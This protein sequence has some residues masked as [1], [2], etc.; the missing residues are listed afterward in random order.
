[1]I[2]VNIAQ[3]DVTLKLDLAGVIR[4]A[5]LGDKISDANLQSWVGRNWAETV[6]DIGADKV[7]RMVWDARNSGVSGFRQVTQ[8]FPSGLELP[9][10]YTTIRLGDNSGLIAVGKSLQAVAELQSRL[11][12]A[13][14]AMERDYWKFREVETRYRLLFDAS[15]EAVLLM[16]AAD[17]VIIE[18]NPAALRS[19]GAGVANGQFLQEID[20]AEREA[21]RAVLLRA[22]EQ[23]RA[24]GMV[25]HLG[26][27]LDPWLLRVSTM[28]A[29]PGPLFLLQLTPAGIAAPIEPSTDPFA[30]PALIAELPEGLVVIDLDG[31]IRRANN[32]FVELIQANGEGG[33]V[34]EKLERWLRA[35]GA[36]LTVILANVRRYNV[37]RQFATTIYDELDAP[38]NVVIAA[39]MQG[40]GDNRS[41][42][43]LFH[44]GEQP[45]GHSQ[46]AALDGITLEVGS[47]P[48]RILLQETVGRLER[49]YIE[50]ALE[51]ASGN[52]TASAELLGLSRQSLYAKLNR[53]GLDGGAR[54][55][56]QRDE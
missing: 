21:F 45:S 32:A 41:V 42:A 12:A 6:V 36:D 26:P 52:R 34:G 37:L 40:E 47:A 14:Q 24:P 25:V 38:L 1:M 19:L 20:P 11:I 39:A 15:N 31:N 23:G 55:T 33:I 35:P 48:L 51:K 44:R 28:I 22:R 10:E 13:Q 2:P 3:P 9:I 30:D 54:T 5:T 53:Y 18:A 43:L 8:R 17:H 49:Y 4:S 46:G 56:Q 27:N 16:R 50:A 7:R 29:E